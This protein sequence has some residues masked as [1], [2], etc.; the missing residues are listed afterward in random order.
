MSN[1]I[2]SSFTALFIVWIELEEK[3]IIAYIF[4]FESL[5]DRG[6]SFIYA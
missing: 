5:S 4:I 6:R 2:K 1:N 3:E